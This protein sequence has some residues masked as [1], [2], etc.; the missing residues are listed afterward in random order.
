[1]NDLII[2]MIIII[3]LTVRMQLSYKCFCF[4][5]ES[6]QWNVTTL[7]HTTVTRVIHLR[8]LRVIL[9]VNVIWRFGVKFP[10]GGILHISSTPSII[11][12]IIIIMFQVAEVRERF[13]Q[14]RAVL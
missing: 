2:M 12:I 11:I 6:Y 3:I 14:I 13:R 8:F 1:V 9:N 7:R 4:P 5:R 10:C